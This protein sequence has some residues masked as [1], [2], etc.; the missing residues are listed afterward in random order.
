MGLRKELQSAIK[1]RHISIAKLAR[2]S[3]IHQE[4]IYNFLKGKSE[5]MAVNLDKL[6]EVLREK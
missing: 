1:K 4:T 5:M 6:F 3:D 2:L